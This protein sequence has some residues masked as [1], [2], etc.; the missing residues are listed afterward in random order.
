MKRYEKQ[1]LFAE[2]G[3]EGQKRLKTSK[4]IVIGCGALGTVICNSLV[5][6]GVGHIKIVDRD[7]IELSN[8]QRQTLFDEKD[9]ADNLPKAIAAKKKLELINSE[10]IIE[11]DV[12]DVNSKNIEKLCK[13]MDLI[14]DAT[15]N[16]NIR[17]LINDISIKLDI[18]W[19][20]GGV[21]GSTGVLSPIIPGKTPC[22]RCFMP[23]LPSSGSIETCDTVGVL[24]GITNMIA[25][26]QSTEA[27][28]ILTQ[29]TK[30]LIKGLLYIDIWDNNF[31]VVNLSKK[32]KCKACS[33]NNYEFLNRKE[34]DA[35]HICGKN[36]VQVNPLNKEISVEHI[37]YKLKA[38]G[39]NPQKNSFFIR[40]EI[41]DIIFTLFYDG[42]A[43]IKNVTDLNKAKS[44]YSKYIGH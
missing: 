25:S 22:F 23:D 17:Y 11:S 8:L 31:E 44:L 42:R 15:D 43:I 2:I 6:A 27:L 24:N 7:Y 20:Y 33:D 5:R 28:K 3:D 14:L 30:N 26:Y 39:V 18:P 21:I 4:V 13:G 16:F 37:I 1:I 29:K 10:I 38:I 12:I 40:F 9:I 19:I 32:D 36:S 35:V 34:E 41:D